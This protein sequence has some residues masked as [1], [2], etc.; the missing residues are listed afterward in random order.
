MTLAEILISFVISSIILLVTTQASF[1]VYQAMQSQ[2]NVSTIQNEAIQAF[3][4]MGQAIRHA[5]TQQGTHKNT[6][7]LKLMVKNSSAPSHTKIGAFQIRKGTAS[8][9]G[10]DAFYTYDSYDKNANGSFKAFFVQQHGHHKNKD[11]VL[12]LQ[13]QNK[14]GV[15]QTDAVIAHVQSMQ[16]ELGIKN[17]VSQ[18]LDWL[19]PHEINDQGRRYPQWKHVRAIKI[20]LK[21]QKGKTPLE[22]ERIF[23]LRN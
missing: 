22:L 8:M 16:I 21:L 20:Y 12:Y 13:T 7:L 19:N 15:L 1:Q 5:Q 9:D 4:M 17:D 10:S 2:H 6:S 18:T 11:G 23:A 14:K 3:H